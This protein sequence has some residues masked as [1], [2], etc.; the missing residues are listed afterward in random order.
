MTYDDGGDDVDEGEYGLGTCQSRENYVITCICGLVIYPV[1]YII[2][3]VYLP[4]T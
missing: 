2:Y 1:I 4:K 3:L